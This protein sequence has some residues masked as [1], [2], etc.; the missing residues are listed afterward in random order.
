MSTDPEPL[1]AVTFDCWN[2]LLY[3]ADWH[4]AHARRVEALHTATFEGGHSVTR[5]T[6][7]IA[8]D[9]A[10]HRHMELWR[11]GVATGAREIAHWALDELGIDSAGGAYDHLVEHW[12]E[13]S[14]SGQVRALDGARETLA[15]LRADGVATALICDTGLTPGRVVRHHLER[16]GLLENLDVQVF[17]DEEGVPKPNAVVFQAALGALGVDAS[18]ALHVGDLRRT[19]VAG[20]H[21]VGM[22][23]ARITDR[24]DDRG[25]LREADFVVADHAELRAVLLDL[26]RAVPPR[27]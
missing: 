17:S 26:R 4:L 1:A 13:A 14:H 21:G 27:S 22:R 11:E 12:Q 15:G 2:T 18:A 8:F 10:W 7:G 24:Y 19:D 23:A 16:L 6:A 3:E 5:E 25:E 20:A 9:S